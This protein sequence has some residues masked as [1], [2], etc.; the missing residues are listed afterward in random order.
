MNES[1]EINEIRTIFQNTQA[2]PERDSTAAASGRAELFK[3]GR[4]FKASRI[5]TTKTAS[6]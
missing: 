5:S 2:V 6:Q 4:I 1:K 3:T